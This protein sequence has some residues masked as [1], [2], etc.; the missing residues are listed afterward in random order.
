MEREKNG[1]GCI[2]LMIR[3]AQDRLTDLDTAKWISL[4]TVVMVELQNGI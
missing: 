3:K 1:L 4:V 2:S